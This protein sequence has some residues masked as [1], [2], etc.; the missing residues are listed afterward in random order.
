MGDTEDVGGGGSL[1]SRPTKRF[2]AVQ[3]P[4]IVNDP[5]Q[6]IAMMGGDRAV[7]SALCD[8]DGELELCLDGRRSETTALHAMR[9]EPGNLVLAE[10]G[11]GGSRGRVVG[12]IYES[13]AFNSLADFYYPC[14][15]NTA[16]QEKLLRNTTTQILEGKAD[17]EIA[18]FPGFFENPEHSNRVERLEALEGGM[19][20]IATGNRKDVAAP[21]AAAGVNDAGPNVA[22]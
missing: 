9:S 14:E 21:V 3:F 8:R 16:V 18:V 12:P 17:D 7:T 15:E 5:A 6:A 20:H 10:V 11:S 22:R 19:G 4:G 13:Y 1:A 2:V